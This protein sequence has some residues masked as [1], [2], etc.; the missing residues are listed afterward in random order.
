MVW[1]NNAGHTVYIN[2][3]RYKTHLI[4]SGVFFGIK[5]II[6]CHGCVVNIKSF[7]S[8]IKY[9]KKH[10]F[11][12]NLI[13]ISPLAH[14]ITEEHIEEDIKIQKLG[15]T[16]RGIAPCYR[17]KYARTG[18]RVKDM[19]HEFEGHIWDGKLEEMFYVK[20]LKDFGWI[21]IMVI[22]H[23]SQVVIPYHM[24]LVA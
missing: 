9:L 1:R 20:E 14:V 24:E 13:K 19:L 3:I 6:A 5:S 12:T 8:E 11:N 17:D 23:I 2:T 15:T 18:K 22:I 10:G 7:Y 16:A 4:P 21:L